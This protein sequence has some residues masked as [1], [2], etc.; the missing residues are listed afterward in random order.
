MSSR[1]VSRANSVSASLGAQSAL[2][3]RRRDPSRSS[4]ALVGRKCGTGRKAS[5]SGPSVKVSSGAY[6]VS[7]NARS[8][9]SVGIPD[10]EQTC[11][12]ASAAPAGAISR[13]RAGVSVPGCPP[14]GTGCWRGA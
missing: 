8:T 10:P 1:D 5:A 7:A 13:G 2:K 9:S 3:V 4:T 12:K 14:T 6:S 11:R